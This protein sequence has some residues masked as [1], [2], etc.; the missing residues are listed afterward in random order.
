M[1]LGLV[2]LGRMG[3]NMVRRLLRDDHRIVAYNR[4]P[5]KVETAVGYGAV[6][7]NSLA[8][9]VE[10]LT[11]PRV[12]WLMVPSGTPVDENLDAVLALLDGGDIVVDGGNS[13]YRRTQERHARAAA[14]GVHYVDSGTSGGIWGLT[15]GY[16]LMV[17]GEAEAVAHLAPALTTLAPPDG[18]LHVGPCGA[19]HFVK[20]LHNGIEYGMLQAMAEGFALLEGSE[21]ELDL[22]KIAHLWNQGSVVRSW[23]MELAER[24]FA[25]DPRLDALEA[26]VDDSGEGR[27]TVDEA[28]RQSIPAPVL[29][30]ALMARFRSRRPDDFGDR[31]IAAL[32]N[33]FGGH[34]VKPRD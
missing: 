23:L 20:M 13:E 31:V 10:Q 17:G 27:W 4:S 34:A 32:R 2:G 21:F 8:H 18:W 19:G 24:A 7:A 3:M 28:V 6:A 22:H 30:L 15:V 9:L 11:P 5:E 12:V 26:Y 33:Q 29:T 14:T 25:E 1:E 16:C